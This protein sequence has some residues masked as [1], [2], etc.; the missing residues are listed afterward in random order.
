MNK[1]PFVFNGDPETRFEIGSVTDGFMF[2]RATRLPGWSGNAY[3]FEHV[4]SG[5]HWLH[6]ETEE[7]QM[8]FSVAFR[9]PVEDDRGIPHILE[10]MVLAGSRKYPSEDLWEDLRQRTCILDARAVTTFGYTDFHFSS[11]I[12]D[13][14]FAVADCVLDAVFNPN[15]DDSVFRREAWRYT[16]VGEDENSLGITGVVYNEMKAKWSWEWID[17]WMF[18]K[19]M[20]GS[21]RSHWS[22]GRPSA[23]LEL[24][25]RD[26]RNY[27]RKWYKSSNAYVITKG[28]ASLEKIRCFLDGFFRGFKRQKIKFPEALFVVSKGEFEEETLEVPANKF[29]D[30]PS[31]L[32]MQKDKEGDG[33]APL[34]KIKEIACWHIPYPAL[35]REHQ[36]LRLAL[37]VMLNKDKGTA[38]LPAGSSQQVVPVHGDPASFIYRMMGHGME[39]ICF[40]NWCNDSER[41]PCKLIQA[42]KDKV[43][44][45]LNDA[46]YVRR[47]VKAARE[48]AEHAR[49]GGKRAPSVS[50][51]MYETYIWVL[52]I[53]DGNPF[54]ERR[55][56]LSDVVYGEIQNNP[57][58]CLELLR[59]I[60]LLNR[61]AVNVELICADGDD[62]EVMD[63]EQGMISR[64]T[65]SA[66][67]KALALD[68]KI[69]KRQ[70]A[71]PRGGKIKLPRTF[72]EDIPPTAWL[73]DYTLEE[74]AVSQARI[75]RIGKSV[76]SSGY[77][78]VYVDCGDLP[79]EQ[80]VWLGVWTRHRCSPLKQ[81]AT[82]RGNGGEAGRRDAEP[83][84]TRFKDESR[85]RAARCDGLLASFQLEAEDGRSRLDA[86]FENLSTRVPVRFGMLC[87]SLRRGRYDFADDLL[88]KYLKKRIAD[89][90]GDVDWT[91][92][93]SEMIRDASLAAD[94]IQ[95]PARWTFVLQATDSLFEECKRKI[96]DRCR[97]GRVEPYRRGMVCLRKD[98]TSS[99]PEGDGIWTRFEECSI[100]TE[101][102]VKIS[103]PIGAELLRL[104]GLEILL[105]CYM[106]DAG[107]AYVEFRKRTGAYTGSCKFNGKAGT[108][109]LFAVRVSDIGRVVNAVRNDLLPYVQQEIK[110]GDTGRAVTTFKDAVRNLALCMIGKAV[111]AYDGDQGERFI[112]NVRRM[113]LGAT[114]EKI[115]NE[116]IGVSK[117]QP[118]SVKKVLLQVLKRG[119]PNMNISAW[120]TRA[121]LEDA[122]KVLPESCRFQLGK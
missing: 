94:K 2:K 121:M 81:N 20:P 104:K 57:D 48:K 85:F 77:C 59:E 64:L 4:K 33:G 105:G 3:E 45:S 69:R 50:Q 89:M 40:W 8:R 74:D 103:I 115:K 60:F 41:R 114:G 22:G 119:L 87:E 30:V 27:H 19:L 18:A 100:D 9:T 68:D 39:N 72:I 55:H 108:I 49:N 46:D 84:F 86:A 44:E 120:A 111:V 32:T 106:I 70:G 11:V 24:S 75:Y 107:F 28:P 90:G 122:N 53:F 113:L 99:E 71:I 36:V 65:T 62:H 112:G 76:G 1:A 35:S 25:N 110:G 92:L 54:L 102:E 51:D 67:K 16:S 95:N 63:A 97:S 83:F 5:A 17:H 43:A 56:H 73:P 82:P 118:N 12:E 38:P 80:Y 109:D 21:S 7:T 101:Q 23:I 37:D 88:Q 29:R 14:Y 78:S 117:K 96:L 10:H 42:I 13:E 52:W 79:F 116:V 93:A 58:E 91:K 6:Y 66:R 26:I 34:R 47:L 98:M 31:P 15:L 61:S